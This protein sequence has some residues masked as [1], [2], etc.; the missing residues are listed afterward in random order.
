[1]STYLGAT[2]NK[3]LSQYVPACPVKGWVRACLATHYRW[4]QPRGFEAWKEHVPSQQGSA[5]VTPSL[6]CLTKSGSLRVRQL[7]E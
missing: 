6:V 2:E 5:G 4:D 1:M 7:W 3:T